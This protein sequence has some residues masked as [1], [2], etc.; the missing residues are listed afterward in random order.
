MEVHLQ[1]RGTQRDLWR[2]LARCWFNPSAKKTYWSQVMFWIYRDFLLQ[3]ILLPDN[4]LLSFFFGT[5]N[6]TNLMLLCSIIS[7]SILRAIHPIF[8]R[9]MQHFLLYFSF[10][11]SICI[12]T[13]TQ[14]QT[15]MLLLPKCS[16]AS[17]L[18][19]KR[20]KKSRFIKCYIFPFSFKTS[21]KITVTIYGYWG[22]V[23]STELRNLEF[24][25]ETFSTHL[26]IIIII[27]NRLNFY[28]Q[29]WVISD[30]F[31]KYFQILVPKCSNNVPWRRSKTSYLNI[32]LQAIRYDDD[33]CQ[34][35][36]SYTSKGVLLLC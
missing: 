14:P 36:Q 25:L 24:V 19:M 28:H 7:F 35:Q 11:L 3:L 31:W 26:D 20:G 29:L 13:N 5:S 18:E 2:A 27:D 30:H 21:P 8:F 23:L 6:Q 1:K 32:K 10:L 17:K 33:I 22:P 15:H 34:F 9:S 12:N 4:D 16:L